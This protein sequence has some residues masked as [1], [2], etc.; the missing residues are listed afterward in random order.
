MA[1]S[2]VINVWSIEK[3]SGALEHIFEVILSK[4]RFGGL[5][6]TQLSIH[7]NFIAISTKMEIFVFHVVMCGEKP[8]KKSGDNRRLSSGCR[9]RSSSPYSNNSPPSPSGDENSSSSSNSEALKNIKA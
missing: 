1:T 2:S 6:F 5:T 7:G 9:G 4:S 3:G 8:N